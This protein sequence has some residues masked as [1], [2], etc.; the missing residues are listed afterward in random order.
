MEEL[1][2]KVREL[3]GE[4][5]ATTVVVGLTF[6]TSA[7]LVRWEQS[8]E[9][10][11]VLDAG[12]ELTQGEPI[13]LTLE[14]MDLRVWGDPH[15]DDAAAPRW[16]AAA[17]VWTALFPPAVVMNLLLEPHTREWPSVLRTLLLTVIL[18]P[19]VVLGTVPLLS[20]ALAAWQSHRRSPHE[21]PGNA[22]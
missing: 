14:A 17:I 10:A 8:E 1:G 12:V 4:D 22:S 19:V 15:R 13:P 2:S 9:R 11:T 5:G 3:R 7:D 20:R 18:V 6:G 21:N 16:R